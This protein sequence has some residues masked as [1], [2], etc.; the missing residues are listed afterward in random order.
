MRQ[1]R[2]QYG[3]LI[4]Q[5]IQVFYDGDLTDHD[6]PVLIETID[7][8]KDN[9]KGEKFVELFSK[10]S[11]SFDSLKSFTKNSLKRINR[12]ADQKKLL[13]ILLSREYT[14]R[15]KELIKQGFINEYDGELLENVLK[16]N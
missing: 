16:G 15:L 4:G 2:L 14:Q 8:Q 10:D 3:I 5:V 9:P 7:F 11:F 6:D 13:N 1:L 12:K